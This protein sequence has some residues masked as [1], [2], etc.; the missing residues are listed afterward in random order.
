MDE[1]TVPSFQ[2]LPLTLMSNVAISSKLI[3]NT[4]LLP[5]T[6]IEHYAIHLLQHNAADAMWFGGLLRC[7]MG[8]RNVHNGTDILRWFVH[9]SYLY[10]FH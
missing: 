2:T 4:D 3:F 8:W 9:R 6:H 1:T 10:S 7:S 5:R